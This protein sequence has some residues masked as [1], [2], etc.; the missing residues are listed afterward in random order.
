MNRKIHVTANKMVVGLPV[1]LQEPALNSCFD[2]SGVILGC[3]A[4]TEKAN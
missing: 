4:K 2:A 1:R 3:E